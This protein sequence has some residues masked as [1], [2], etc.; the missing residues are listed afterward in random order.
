M[1]TTTTTASPLLQNK[2]YRIDSIDMLRGLV[3]IIMA[4]DHTRDFFHQQAWTDDPLNLQTTT[5]ALYFTR[6]VTHLCAPIFVFLAGTGAYFQSLRK[7]KKELSMFLLKRGFWL[8]I[9]EIFIINFAFSFDIHYSV[10]GLQTIWSI[11]ISMI[12][13][14]LVVWLPFNA[15]LII[16]SLLVLG[17][18]ALDYFEAGKTS[19]PGWW[20][21]MLH[22]PNFYHLWGR[23]NLLILYPFVPWAGLMMLGYCFGKLFLKY[24]GGQRTKMLVMLG[25]GLLV[26][27]A[28]LRAPNIYGDPQHWTSQK[29]GLYSFLSFMNVQKYPPSLL[30]MCA[31]IGIG[32]LILAAMG[33]VRNWFTRFITVYG[34]VPF[35]YYVLHFFLIHLVSSIFY[36]ARGHSFA[37]GVQPKQGGFLPN[38]VDPTQ[39]VSLFWVYVI[40][41]CIVISLYPVC[42]WFSEYKKRH[43]DWWLSYI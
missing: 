40:W 11:G 22:H 20:Y 18:N 9:V 16:G 2:A 23:H 10:I 39:G 4:L 7:S 14:G 36:L 15:I 27:F 31:T 26:L 6:W 42:K 3:M 24:E 8:L 41:L 5:P 19:S 21:D 38:F 35:L 17:H 32:L 13:L 25:L 30:Y 34:R 43:K 12:I 1:T 33:N 28:I 37:E 29:N